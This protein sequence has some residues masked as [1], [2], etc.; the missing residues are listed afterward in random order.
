MR[1]E[2]RNKRTALWEEDHDALL[3]SDG[4][5]IPGKIVGTRK[6]DGILAL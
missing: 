1:D 4:F 6:H 2:K 5:L 3:S